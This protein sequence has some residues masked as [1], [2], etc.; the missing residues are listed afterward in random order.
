MAVF[1]LVRIVV[2]AYSYG[3][4][5]RRHVNLVIVGRNLTS[6][7][8]VNLLTP[9]LKR[10]KTSRMNILSPLGDGIPEYA[11]L[12]ISGP[13]IFFIKYDISEGETGEEGETLTRLR[14]RELAVNIIYYSFSFLTMIS[15]ECYCPPYLIVLFPNSATSTPKRL[16]T[17]P[18]KNCDVAMW[19][20]V[21]RSRHRNATIIEFS[22]LSHLPSPPVLLSPHL[23]LAFSVKNISDT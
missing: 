17:T 6:S 11:I 23:L 14:E 22:P 19:Q 3:G 1:S 9:D 21:R 7:S 5:S 20:D 18:S 15:A 10:L 2:S 8:T 4:P 12:I 16:S 13:S